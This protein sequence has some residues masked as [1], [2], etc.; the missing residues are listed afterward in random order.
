MPAANQRVL[1]LAR[2]REEGPEHETGQS[3]V[4]LVSFIVALAIG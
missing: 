1:P 4:W 3:H 2:Y